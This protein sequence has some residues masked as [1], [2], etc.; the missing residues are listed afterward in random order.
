MS[1]KPTPLGKIEGRPAYLP[2]QYIYPA[3]APKLPPG[4]APSIEAVARSFAPKGNA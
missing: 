4:V 2:V 1:G 3:N